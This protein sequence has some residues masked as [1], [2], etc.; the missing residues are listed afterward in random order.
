MKA[1][2][3]A[4]DT[5]MSDNVVDKECGSAA[6]EGVP[7]TEKHLN[8][9]EAQ[10]NALSYSLSELADKISPSK[11]D[12][13]DDEELETKQ[14]S[15]TVGADRRNSLSRGKI[16]GDVGSAPHSKSPYSRKNE[17]ETKPY[18][19]KQKSFN[20]NKPLV[21]SK[22][23][24]LSDDDKARSSDM[25]TEE[26]ESIEK[27]EIMFK[28]ASPS[29]QESI[30]SGYNSSWSAS[31]LSEDFKNFKR[32][33]TDVD[34]DVDVDLKDLNEETLKD[35]T[36]TDEQQKNET[37]AAEYEKAL[38]QKISD[39]EKRINS[40]ILGGNS[41]D[42]E[43][44]ET[45][46]NSDKQSSEP[47]ESE[48]KNTSQNGEGILKDEK[49]EIL[50]NGFQDESHA[51]KTDLN[52]N[53]RISEKSK[54][55]DRELSHK[56]PFHIRK[57][58]KSSLDESSVNPKP[59]RPGLVRRRT[60]LVTFRAPRQA[61]AFNEVDDSG[62]LE[63]DEAGFVQCLTDVRAVKTMLLKLKRELQEVSLLN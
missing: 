15:E 20:K 19:S 25:Q 26:S 43:T 35:G 50:T 17:T 11:T 58:R 28:A 8:L 12:Y 53:N 51:S 54:S 30:E 18:L 24:N 52:Q 41:I 57:V 22:E 40:L 21:T 10:L 37:S 3:V 47:Q 23:L 45:E 49:V 48:D 13:F 44:N 2:A 33:S 34:T 60:T 6:Q 32:S 61:F 59:K 27:E 56:S 1:N 63:I 38:Q 46:D 7:P 62:V 36:N 9:S 42:S 55:L 14:K 39:V 31:S 16:P 5:K 4:T 29:H